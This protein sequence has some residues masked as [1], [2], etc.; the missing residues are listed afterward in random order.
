MIQL[1]PSTVGHHAP[2]V[3]VYAT[4]KAGH[5][6]LGQSMPRGSWHSDSLQHNAA[7]NGVRA[8]H[9]RIEQAV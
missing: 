5:S 1:A 7:V 2:A 8:Q 3:P 4:L 6:L 9:S